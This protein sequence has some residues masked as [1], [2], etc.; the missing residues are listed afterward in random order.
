MP[1]TSSCPSARSAPSLP[2]P[3]PVSAATLP[4]GPSLQPGSRAVRAA[5]VVRRS[6]RSQPAPGSRSDLSL[7]FDRSGG[8]QACP[9]EGWPWSSSVRGTV[10]GL[11][12]FCRRRGLRSGF[13]RGGQEE[14]RVEWRYI[15]PGKPMQNGIVESFNGRLRD[16][17]LN[18]HLVA[19]L[20]HARHLIRAWRNDCNHHRPPHVPRRAHPVGV[21]PP[22]KTGPNPAQGEPINAD[23]RGSTSSPLGTL[24]RKAMAASVTLASD[25]QEPGPA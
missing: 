2:V 21:S 11:P 8:V 7:G 22:V 24:L 17:C 20:R 5:G 19:N 9:T 10:P 25:P 13:W 18:E 1:T 4:V 14:R 3:G 6:C 15:A 12:P 16:E 23:S